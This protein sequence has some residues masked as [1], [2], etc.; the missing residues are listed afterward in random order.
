MINGEPMAG[1]IDGGPGYWAGQGPAW[2]RATVTARWG[3]RVARAAGRLRRGVGAGSPAAWSAA[4]CPERTGAA[5]PRAAPALSLP[6]R[7]AIAPG[8]TAPR[9][10][11]SSSRT[12]PRG[13]NAERYWDAQFRASGQEFDRSAGRAVRAGG[14][15]SCG[16]QALPRN[17]A[18]YCSG[19][20]FIAYDVNWSVAAFRRSATRSCSTCSG[21][22]TPTACRC[23]W[24]SATPSPSSRSCRPTAWPGRTSARS[25]RVQLTLDEGDLEEFREGLP[26]VGDDPDQPWF[27]EGSH[28]TSEQRTDYFFRGYERPGGLQP[29]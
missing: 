17:N 2:G 26:A 12:S 20:D 4:S 14:R 16:G 27:A 22:S 28:G 13:E 19:G 29:G 18:V 25:I 8:P 10:S 15:V 7:C 3:R 23:G 5:R 11:P 21:T 24:G 6:D 1:M 9:A